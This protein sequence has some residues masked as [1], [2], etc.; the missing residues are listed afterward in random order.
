MDRRESLTVG[1]ASLPA[2]FRTTPVS[3]HIQPRQAGTPAATPE[4]KRAE[5]H[6]T[7]YRVK[8]LALF[9]FLTSAFA[10]VSAAETNRADQTL[11]LPGETFQVAAHRAF[12]I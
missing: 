9:L 12:L 11:P 4:T 8:P 7:L 1:R 5:A 10:F 3:F 2:I 6:P